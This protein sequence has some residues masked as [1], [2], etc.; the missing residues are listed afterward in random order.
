MIRCGHGAVTRER[1]AP[2]WGP[3]FP[4]RAGVTSSV[5]R[6][7]TTFRASRK[8][9]ASG[10]SEP[11]E[12]RTPLHA[13]EL[14]TLSCGG[15]NRHTAQYSGQFSW[16]QS[17]QG[18]PRRRTRTPLSVALLGGDASSR[19]HPRWR[20]ASGFCAR[21]ERPRRQ[22]SSHQLEVL[23]RYLPA[24]RRR[25]RPARLGR[26]L[27]RKCRR[28]LAGQRRSS[29]GDHCCRPAELT[30]RWFFVEAEAASA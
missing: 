12:R 11:T 7:C 16:L 17:E 27:Q 3:A 19:G 23:F 26:D 6:A 18:R 5:R 21:A 22:I 29:V 15:R 10:H 9:I 30:A 25:S 13:M 8:Y 1:P 28:F 20:P 4:V 24:R 14:L 2:R